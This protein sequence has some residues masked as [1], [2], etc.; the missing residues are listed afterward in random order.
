MN[1][2]TV[3]FTSILFSIS[4]FSQSGVSH[5]GFDELLLKYVDDQGMV[6]YK[7]LKSD[8]VKLKSYLSILESNAPQ[9]SWTR[10]QKLAYWIN[11]YNAYTLDLILEH[12]PV[13]SIKDIGSTIK[14]PFVSTA[15]DIK[16]INIGGEEYDL[17]NIEHGIIR[18][19]FDEPRIHFAL[20]CAAVSCPKLQN[21]AYLPEKLDD[22]LAKAAKEFLG[23]PAKNSIK[24]AN[25]ATLSKLFN[26]YGGDF[27]K[28]GTLIDY[29][30][31]YADTKL[32]KV[33]DIDWMDYNWQLNEQK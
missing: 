25:K 11:A 6:N 28:D 2:F 7:G 13:K 33:A 20:V 24:S 17:N 12:Y 5:S 1:K 23:N 19:E 16:F 9:K 30:N 27:K 4:L 10:D 3:F 22:Q 18:K 26:W 32:S 21:R 29:I 8:R 14:I 15:W 31:R